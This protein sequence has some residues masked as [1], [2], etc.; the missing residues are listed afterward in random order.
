MKNLTLTELELEVQREKIKKAETRIRISRVITTIMAEILE[1]EEG[2]ERI[3]K[4]I[5]TVM[6]NL[7]I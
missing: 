2:E 1:Q 3:M 5:V 4:K 6:M 7:W